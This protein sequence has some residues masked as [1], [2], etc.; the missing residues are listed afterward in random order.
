MGCFRGADIRGAFSWVCCTFRGP[1]RLLANSRAV[2]RMGA[3]RKERRSGSVVEKG[4]TRLLSLLTKR[5]N[6]GCAGQKLRRLGAFPATHPT[7]ETQCQR[8]R[9]RFPNSQHLGV[10]RT[11]EKARSELKIQTE[12]GSASVSLAFLGRRKIDGEN[13]SPSCRIE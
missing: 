1:T 10:I 7:E 11:P 2:G 8:K 9:T 5:E 4:V 13:C 6:Q 3:V 12:A